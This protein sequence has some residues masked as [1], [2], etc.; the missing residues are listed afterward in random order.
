MKVIGK[1]G[2]SLATVLSG[3]CISYLAFNQ[4]DSFNSAVNKYINVEVPNRQQLRDTGPQ[5]L[6]FLVAQFP[7]QILNLT[8]SDHFF[9]RD[10]SQKVISSASLPKGFSFDAFLEEVPGS[11][12]TTLARNTFVDEDYFAINSEVVQKSEKELSDAFRQL[13]SCLPTSR[14]CARWFTESAFHGGKSGHNLYKT[15]FWHP[16]DE[17]H[18]ETVSSVEEIILFLKALRKH[19]ELE[20]HRSLILKNNGLDLLRLVSI[21]YTDVRITRLVSHVLGNLALDETSHKEILQK[22]W[23]RELQTWIKSKDIVVKSH[24]VRA[25]AN[26]DRDG[27]RGHTYEDG[28][29]VA[30]PDKQ[31]KCCRPEVDLVFVHGLR[32]S[33]FRT[34]RGRTDKTVEGKQTDC[35][36]R[37]WFPVDVPRCR[38]ILVEYDTEVSGWTSKCPMQPEISTIE[39]RSSELLNKLKNAGV[40]RRPVVWIAHSL[41]GLMVKQMLLD[42]KKSL[43]FCSLHVNTK[44]VVF[45]AVPHRGSDIAS[46]VSGKARYF[47]LPSFEVKAL[48]K[49]SEY[50]ENLQ[51]DFVDFVQENNVDVL[52]FAETQPARIVRD[53]LIVSSDSA[54]L[55]VGDFIP[56]PAN[57]YDVCKPC[58]RW[59]PAYMRT[60]NF[61]KQQLDMVD[62]EDFMPA[63]LF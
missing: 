28:I 20:R 16:E 54:D 4:T 29:F 26:L 3:S 1:L 45:Y 62:I 44:G 23:L 37:D 56:L 57:H 12:L 50:L 17:D 18:L 60:V 48:Q 49:G 31:L 6:G 41:G 24:S 27:E 2:I 36:P 30:Y 8:Q 5:V 39:Y 38:V 59:D 22:G 51:K 11:T 40:G 10:L 21:S 25:L 42:A 46:M 53:T 61:V 15:I 34:W 7:K 9:I 35:W 32:G 19:S 47:L 14:Q 13:L 63:L 43:E 33:P 55:G 58:S 52:S